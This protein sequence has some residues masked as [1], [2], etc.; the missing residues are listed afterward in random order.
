MSD[1]KKAANELS[2]KAAFNAAKDRAERAIQDALST[3]EERAQRKAEREALAKKKRTKW[4][5]LGVIGLVLLIG[6]VG[7]A[8]RYWHWFLFAGLVAVAALYGR[9]RWRKFRSAQKK[10]PV[11]PRVVE[12]EVVEERREEPPLVQQTSTE[13]DTSIEDELAALKARVK[14]RT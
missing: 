5:I 13:P 7:M 2:A 8:L 10:E 11:A 1:L 12:T 3:E 6:I 9:Y 14:K 4:I